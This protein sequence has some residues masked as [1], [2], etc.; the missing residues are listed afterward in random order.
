MFNYNAK[1]NTQSGNPGNGFILWNN[2]TQISSTTISINH[3]TAN[4]VQDIDIFLGLLQTGQTLTVQDRNDSTNYQTWIINGTPVETVANEY[5]TVPV[6]LQG[7]GG[8]GTTNFSNNHN[9]F[10]AIFAPSGSSGTSGSSGQN[11][12]SGSSGQNGSSGSSGHYTRHYY[13]RTCP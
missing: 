1:T 12:S 5:W 7:S 2:A 6:A 13:V 3:L 10:I 11:G 9:I 4:P 8:S